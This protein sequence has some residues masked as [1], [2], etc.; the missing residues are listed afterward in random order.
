MALVTEQPHHPHELVLLR[1]VRD[2][3]DRECAST[4]RRAARVR[5]APLGWPQ[6]QEV[7]Y[8]VQ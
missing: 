1:R 8:G 4:Q 2:R 7:H 6:E 3:T 5:S